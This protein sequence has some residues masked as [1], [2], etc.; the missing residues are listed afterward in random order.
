MTYYIKP[1]SMEEYKKDHNEIWPEMERLINDAGYRNYSIFARDDGQLFAYWEHEDLKKGE[2][3]LQDSPISLK[4][5]TMMNKYFIKI[6][7]S[8]IGPESVDL[9]EVWHQD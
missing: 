1:E 7:Q 2:K 3:I 9:N 6:D 4:W 5:E 8:I